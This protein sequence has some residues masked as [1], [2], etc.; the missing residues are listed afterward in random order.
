MRPVKPTTSLPLSYQ[1]AQILQQS[2]C[3]L[4]T[5]IL[6]PP[7]FVISI[8][9]EAKHDSPA[10]TRDKEEKG[11]KCIEGLTDRVHESIIPHKR[12]AP[13]GVLLVWVLGLFVAPV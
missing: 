11:R 8:G 4:P 5:N 12:T 2:T 13:I 1:K 7:A 3:G 9:S 6:T 10:D